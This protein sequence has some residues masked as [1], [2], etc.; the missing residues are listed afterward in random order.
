MRFP[1]FEMDNG[2]VSSSA[3]LPTL[4]YR[5]RLGSDRKGCH[6]TAIMSMTE[7]NDQANHAP[8]RASRKCLGQA[9]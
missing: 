6:Q 2:D 5:P 7:V 3:A 8:K 9:D 4:V 1:T